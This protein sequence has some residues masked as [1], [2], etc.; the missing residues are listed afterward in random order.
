MAYFELEIVAMFDVTGGLDDEELLGIIWEHIFCALSEG[1]QMQQVYQ[2]MARNNQ[3]AVAAAKHWQQQ[4]E[5][6]EA[7]EEA[8][9]AAAQSQC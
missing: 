8:S 9:I 4:L 1:V 2:L 7:H 6:R 3:A 5:R